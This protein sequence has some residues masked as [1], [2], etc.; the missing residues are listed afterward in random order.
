MSTSM[1]QSWASGPF[2]LVVEHDKSDIVDGPFGSR[3]KSSEYQETGVP[4]LR[5]QNIQRNEFLKKNFKY[6]SLAKSNDLARHSYKPGD[7]VL[8]KLGAPL[9][10]ACIVPLDFPE[11]NIV[12][13]LVR[14]RVN[15]SKVDKHFICYQINSPKVIEQFSKNTKGTTRPRVNLTKVRELE[16]VLPPKPE[17]IRI[18]NKIETCFEKVAATDEALKKAEVLIGKYKEALLA[19]AFRGELE[20]QDPSDEPASQLLE[21]IRTEREQDDAGKKR[22]KKTEFAPITDD[23]KPFDIPDS[24]EWVRFGEITNNLD[25]KR[26][27][28]KSSDRKKR[29]GLYPYYGAS[30]IIDYFDDYIF[31]GEHLLVSEDGA[32]LLARTY[33]IAFIADGKFWVNN[34]AHIVKAREVTSNRFLELYFAATN[35]SRWVTGAAQPKFNQAKLNAMPIPLPPL[36]EQERVLKQL[37]YALKIQLETME[38]MAQIRISSENIRKSTLKKAF[39]GELV[40]QITS[41]GTGHQ[42]LEEILAEKAKLEAVKP[43]KKTSKKTRKKKS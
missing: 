19:K 42:L 7:I 17:Q 29:S 6:I 25:G 31:E 36:G 13:D 16:I 12:A 39:N 10:K 4:I 28:I 2:T 8:T 5:L 26:V 24:W 1:P 35:I 3:L 34:H 41:E 21:R 22:K 30:G 20:P 27:P 23:E 14:V 43:N 11:G 9:G 37:D 38:K 18:V 32:N 15:E 40:D 33:P